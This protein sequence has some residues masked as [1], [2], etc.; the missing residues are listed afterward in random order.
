LKWIIILVIE[1]LRI[2]MRGFGWWEGKRGRGKG[3]GEASVGGS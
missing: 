1:I 2:W 3:R